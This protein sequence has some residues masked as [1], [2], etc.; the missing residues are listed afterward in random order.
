[1]VT[2]A[3][4]PTDVPGETI[5]RIGKHLLRLDSAG[6]TFEL[7]ARGE[8]TE[9]DAKEIFDTLAKWSAGRSYMLVT[10]DMSELSSI[11][12]AA[13]KV[14][15]REGQRVPL[16]GVVYYRATFQAKVINRLMVG[17]YSLINHTD[18]PLYFAENEAD[19]K[20]WLANRRQVLQAEAHRQAVAT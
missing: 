3:S 11:S 13:K 20:V 1:M 10:G 12:P 14:I 19:A 9:D 16:R 7:Q 4:P 2:Y 17:A 8:L 18:I 15:L 6:D 5:Q